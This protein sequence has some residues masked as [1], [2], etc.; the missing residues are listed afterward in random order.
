[1]EGLGHHYDRHD[2]ALDAFHEADRLATHLSL[3][4]GTYPSVLGY[5]SESSIGREAYG[6]GA[7][8]G[9]L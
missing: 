1:M 8:Q 9:Y 4:P 7:F 3:L 5:P 6:A 2:P